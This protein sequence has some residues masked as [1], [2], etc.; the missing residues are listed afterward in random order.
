MMAACE[1]CGF[2][3]SSDRSLSDDATAHEAAHL[4]AFPDSSQGTKVALRFMVDS[5]KRQEAA[6]S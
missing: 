1:A 3:H 6:M 4:A 5:A 2:A